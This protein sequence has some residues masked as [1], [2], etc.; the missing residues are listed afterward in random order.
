MLKRFYLILSLMLSGLFPAS[1]AAQNDVNFTLTVTIE[2]IASDR[3]HI[4]FGIFNDA[5]GF[6]EEGKE[7]QGKRVQAE[8]GSLKMQVSLPPGRYAIACYHDENDNLK[9]DTGF[10]GV[11]VEGFCFSN[12]PNLSLRP[13]SFDEAVFEVKENTHTEIKLR[14]LMP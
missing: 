4:A 14:Y 9:L 5:K 10:L 7:L 6:L 13:P 3:G 2:Q 1:V 11:P 12:N 8:K